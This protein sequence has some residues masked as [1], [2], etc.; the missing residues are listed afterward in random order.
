MGVFKCLCNAVIFVW[1]YR[2]IV[3]ETIFKPSEIIF[4]LFVW[5]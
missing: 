3:L 5:L 2:W 1:I 4:V